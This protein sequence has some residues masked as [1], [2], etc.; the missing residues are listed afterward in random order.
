MGDSEMIKKIPSPQICSRLRN[1]FGSLE[2]RVPGGRGVDGHS[3]AVGFAGIRGVFKRG[4][5][6]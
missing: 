1:E 3:E 5:E 2:L 4:I 6:R